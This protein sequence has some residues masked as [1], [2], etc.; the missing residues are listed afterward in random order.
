MNS[1]AGGHSIF[2][3]STDARTKDGARKPHDGGGGDCS[4]EFPSPVRAGRVQTWGPAV[5]DG[6][7]RRTLAAKSARFEDGVGTPPTPSHRCTVCSYVSSVQL[8][9]IDVPFG[10][11]CQGGYPSSPV[12]ERRIVEFGSSCQGGYPSSPLWTQSDAQTEDGHAMVK[13]DTFP[14]S[15]ALEPRS[16]WMFQMVLPTTA[17][18]HRDRP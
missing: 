17:R 10:S 14:F 18:Q 1:S 13:L 9:S 12:Q 6:K 15:P 16:P 8:R 3:V 2:Q 11:S 5:L 7:R 4:Q